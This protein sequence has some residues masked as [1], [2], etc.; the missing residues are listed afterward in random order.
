MTRYS[1]LLVFALSNPGFSE[2]VS[3]SGA[4]GVSIGMPVDVAIS[5]LD[6]YIST[7]KDYDEGWGCYEILNQSKPEL[8]L[9]FIVGGKVSSI[10]FSSASDK[11][12]G[13][14]GVGSTK[15]HI[16][17]AYDRVKIKP[18][19]YYAAGEYLLVKL[20]NG[21]GFHFETKNNIV[22]RFYLTGSPEIVM[23]EGCL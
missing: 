14:I 4:M 20:S 19:K 21:N 16:K 3:D 11:A 22:I 15:S 2:S 23:V 12:E 9:F 10:Q 17:K 13:G 5:K 8:P 7:E 6:G 18:H 1:L